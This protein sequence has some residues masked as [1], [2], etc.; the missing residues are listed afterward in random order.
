MHF[1]RVLRVAGLPIGPGRVIDALEAI[2]ETGLESRQDLY[3]TLHACFISHPRQR[4]VFDQ[5]FHVF[6][7]N[8]RLL[9]R[10]MSL[11]MPEFRAPGTDRGIELNQ[12]LADALQPGKNEAPSAQPTETVEEDFQATLTWSDREE[13]R[14]MDFESMSADELRDAERAIARMRLHLHPVPTRR[15]SLGRG[16]RI[17]PRASLRASMRKPAAG[18]SLVRRQRRTRAPAIVVLCDVSG[19]MSQYSR[20]ML[21]FLHALTSARDRV[22]SF[23]FGTR[24]TNITR[25]LSER[26]VDVALDSVSEA[27]LDWSG[28]T[29]IG[30]T[31]RDFNRH[32]SR[33]V[34]AQGAVVLLITDGLD[35]DVGEGLSAEMMRLR[36]SCRRLVWLNPLLRY[37]GFEP[38]AL[39]A[40]AML[41]YV[42][43]FRTIHNLNAMSDLAR[44][45]SQAPEASRADLTRWQSMLSEIQTD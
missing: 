32:W 10:M 25:H 18:I 2:Q 26:D 1:A 29:R 7:R 6:W 16:E 40:Q 31:I 12:R 5:A 23:V 27:V 9:E 41:P 34:L 19:S 28:G 8:P 17:D 3:W 20:M 38:K 22:F 44:V 30:Q 37:D 36:R 11:V 13:L 15:F 35:R 14:E 42:D 24:L 33:R 4:E 43:D 45:L 39:G 21:H